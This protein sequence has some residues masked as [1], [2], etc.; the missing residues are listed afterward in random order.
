MKRN[1]NSDWLM[2]EN[3]RKKIYIL[4]FSIISWWFMCSLTIVYSVSQQQQ[5]HWVRIDLNKV[6]IRFSFISFLSS[7]DLLCLFTPLIAVCAHKIINYVHGSN[8]YPSI[9]ECNQFSTY[10]KDIQFWDICQM[11]LVNELIKRM[12]CTVFRK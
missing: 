3:V 2:N 7:T 8:R 1:W 6:K 12:K 9:V 5:Q 11:Y 4:H 10:W